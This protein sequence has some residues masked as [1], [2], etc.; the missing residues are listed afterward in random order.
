MLLT[1][2]LCKVDF[3]STPGK[4]LMPPAPPRPPGMAAPAAMKEGEIQGCILTPELMA[5]IALQQLWK[6]SSPQRVNM[7]SCALV[8]SDS[9]PC[10][11]MWRRA[12][13]IRK[14]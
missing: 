8:A 2:N 11:D 3:G 13:L 5:P 14:D 7:A 9:T 10:E 1:H 4:P 6:L 12:W